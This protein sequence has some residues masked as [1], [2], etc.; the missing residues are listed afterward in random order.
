MNEVNRYGNT[1]ANTRWAIGVALAL[2]IS[3]ASANDAWM[4]TKRVEVLNNRAT[5]EENLDKITIGNQAVKGLDN[6]E[7]YVN[8]AARH[9]AIIQG[10]EMF[11]PAPDG[12]VYP[13]DIFTQIGAAII[14][15]EQAMY[16]M[17]SNRQTAKSAGYAAVRPP[18]RVLD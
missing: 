18:V 14:R 1:G 3:G 10:E 6:A 13:K 8:E 16:A 17:D 12:Q 11:K 9:L 2:A 4:D 15:L 7:F 5:S